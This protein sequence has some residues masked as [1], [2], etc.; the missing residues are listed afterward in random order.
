MQ[1]L[2]CPRS[3]EPVCLMRPHRDSRALLGLRGTPWLARGLGSL[4]LSQQKAKPFPVF[5]RAERFF[6]KISLVI[7]KGT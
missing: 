5:T 3:L 1:H 2:S 7:W 6:A 4:L